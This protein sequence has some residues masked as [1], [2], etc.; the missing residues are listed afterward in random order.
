MRI[1]QTNVSLKDYRLQKQDSEDLQRAL[2]N[3]QVIGADIDTQV[4]FMT[5]QPPRKVCMLQEQT[6]KELNLSKI[7]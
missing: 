2:L 1:T 7:I 3:R 4:D 6:A 5:E